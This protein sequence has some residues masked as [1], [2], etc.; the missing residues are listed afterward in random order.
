L[1]AAA[2]AELILMQPPLKAS[3][4]VDEVS[5]NLVIGRSPRREHCHNLMKAIVTLKIQ[6]INTGPIPAWLSSRHLSLRI[7]VHHKSVIAE[8]HCT[9]AQRE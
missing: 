5:H 8:L 3:A 1:L 9:T 7:A 4:Q 2:R 6:R